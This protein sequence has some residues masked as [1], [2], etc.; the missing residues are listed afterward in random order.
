MVL[1]SGSLGFD[2]P[3]GLGSPEW[4]LK[5]NRCLL[6]GKL[7]FVQDVRQQLERL[8]KEVRPW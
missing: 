3:P 4:V 6:M 7:S 1:A 2:S 5:V 8:G